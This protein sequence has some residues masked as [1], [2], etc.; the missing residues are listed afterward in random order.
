MDFEWVGRS[1]VALLLAALVLS[2]GTAAA[3]SMLV[4]DP[5]PVVPVTGSLSNSDNL[6]VD[7]QSLDYQGVDVT[8]VDVAV[9]NTAAVSH[10]VT[11]YVELENASGATVATATVS[12]TVAAGNVETVTASFAESY[13][14]ANV[15]RI[16]VTVEQTG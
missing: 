15:S 2:A 9:N 12:D 10:D 5:A 16:E 14:V 13:S 6:T 7:S 1:P 3:T 11:L 4:R 8:G